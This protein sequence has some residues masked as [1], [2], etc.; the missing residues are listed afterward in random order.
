MWVGTIGVN[1]NASKNKVT[2]IAFYQYNCIDKYR[3]GPSQPPKK[4]VS[5]ISDRLGRI[6]RAVLKLTSTA[7]SYNQWLQKQKS[8]LKLP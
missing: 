1:L 8:T 4:Q 7:P 5:L 2:G 3:T 6:I